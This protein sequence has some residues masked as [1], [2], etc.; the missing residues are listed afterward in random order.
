NK[1]FLSLKN[2]LKPKGS[3]VFNLNIYGG[4]L[5]DIKLI[6]ENFPKVTIYKKNTSGNIIVVAEKESLNVSK[7][8]LMKRAESIDQKISANFKFKDLLNLEK[9]LNGLGKK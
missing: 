6:K 8:I 1:F 5:K 7:E 4:Y 2:N 9:D 3:V